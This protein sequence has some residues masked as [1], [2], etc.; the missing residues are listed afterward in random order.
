M[1][2]Y[3]FS[4]TNFLDWRTLYLIKISINSLSDPKGEV[5]LFEGFLLILKKE[6]KGGSRINHPYLNSKRLEKFLV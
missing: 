6:T 5:I 4:F 1:G 2:S 3:G